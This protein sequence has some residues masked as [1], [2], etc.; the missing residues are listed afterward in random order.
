MRNP[1]HVAVLN[2][3]GINIVECLDLEQ[4][5][6][7]ARR[8][9]RYEFAITFAPIP[10]KGAPDRRSILWRF[11]EGLTSTRSLFLRP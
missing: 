5:V 4:A 9:N 6:T 10:L 1:I 8:L 3:V 11:S 7:T 2:W